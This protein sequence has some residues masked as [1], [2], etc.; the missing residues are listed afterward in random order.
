M[1]LRAIQSGSGSRIKVLAS[2]SRRPHIRIETVGRKLC[3]LGPLLLMLCSTL[4]LSQT[5]KQSGQ[6]S[7]NSAAGINQIQHIIF[8]IKENRSFDHY[9]GTFPGADGA[10]S[11]EISTGQVIPLGLAPDVT[12]NDVC[13]SWQCARTAVN[14]GLMNQFDLLAGGNINGAYLAYTQYQQNDI[15]NYWTYAQ[16]YALADHMFS[17]L[18]GPSFPNHLYTVGAQSG[19][20]INN[21]YWGRWGCD[22]DVTNVA[23]ALDSKSNL[24]NVPPC[25]DFPTLADSLN[26]AGIAW[27]YYAPL[28]DHVGYQWSAFN[29]VQH[30]RNGP[31]WA[32]NVVPDTQFI[33]DALSGN[34]PPVSWLVTGDASE[35]PPASVCLGENWT[36][37][38]LNALMQGPSWNSSAVFVTW[39]DFGGFYDH[40]PPPDLDQFGLGPRVPLLII[41]PYSIPGYVSHTQYELSSLLKFVETRYNLAPLTA[42]DAEASDITDSFN[43]LQQPLPPMVLPTRTCPAGVSVL[44]DSMFMSP[45]LVGHSGIPVQVDVINSPS[46]TPLSISSIQVSGTNPNDFSET[47]NCVSGSPLAPGAACTIAVTFTPTAPQLRAANIVINDNGPGNPHNVVLTATGLLVKVFVSPSSL[48]FPPQLVGTS[49]GSRNVVLTNTGTAAAHVSSVTITG[50]NPSDFHETDDCVSGSPIPLK[51]KCTIKVTFKPQASGAR[52]A[53]L[54]VNDDANPGSQTVS[55]S[56]DGDSAKL[57]PAG[58]VWKAQIVGTTVSHS[59]TLTNSSTTNTLTVTSIVLGGTNASDFTETDNCV[60]AGSIPVGG[61]CTIT[62]SFTPSVLGPES[63]SLS[64]T[65]NGGASPQSLPLVGT[66]TIVKLSAGVLSFAPR[67]V[68][69]TSKPSMLTVT[70]ASTSAVLHITS[71][72]V[73]GT[74]ASDFAETDNCVSGSPIGPGLKCSIQ[75][76][77]TPGATGSRTGTLSITDDGGGSPQIVNLSGAGQ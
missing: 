19:S 44:P 26:A 30:I 64:I 33:A 67:T 59:A 74:N 72:A 52:S 20:I 77:F 54:T 66:G 32:Q 5:A 45:Q 56:G 53:I 27:G 36:V 14:G 63:A 43:F 39:D 25:V 38:Q 48:P 68:G 28:Q 61:K 34:L 65:D 76:T 11:G 73:G 8:I 17:S 22:S 55:L 1:T 75:V 7:Q 3:R 21:P 2:G 13:H 49:S 18:I 47:D 4:V 70:N 71:V 62:A 46:G 51:G 42:R 37:Q 41:S 60:S 35:H 50:T 15:P 69:T 58:L 6:V 31:Q 29:G 10:T 12:P 40:V 24:I 9:F 57:T 16:T 23:Q